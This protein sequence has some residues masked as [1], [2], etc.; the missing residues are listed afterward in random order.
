MF[1]ELRI[2]QSEQIFFKTFFSRFSKFLSL[3]FIPIAVEKTLEVSPQ[4]VCVENHYY[5][6]ASSSN[7]TSFSA[8]YSP[9][10]Q[11]NS[12]SDSGTLSSSEDDEDEE[13]HALETDGEW[14]LLPDGTKQVQAHTVIQLVPVCVMFYRHPDFQPVQGDR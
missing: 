13:G 8:P 9:R 12:A 7:Y 11:Y 10:Q 14:T 3:F 1:A 2:T 4:V 5:G 6:L